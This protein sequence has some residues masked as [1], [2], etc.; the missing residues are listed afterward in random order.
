[1]DEIKKKSD[2]VVRACGRMKH[3]IAVLAKRADK[4]S[5][6]LCACGVSASRHR[7]ASSTQNG[8]GKPFDDPAPGKDAVNFFRIAYNARAR[9]RR[10]TRA[11]KRR[12]IWTG[13]SR[14]ENTYSARQTEGQGDRGP[15]EGLGRPVGQKE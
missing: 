10:A 8:V 1:M 9:K 13:E 4:R 11:R 6:C 2:D 12:R 3:M 5:A 14:S 7:P 15:K